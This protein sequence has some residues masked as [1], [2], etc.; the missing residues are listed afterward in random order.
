MS[1]KHYSFGIIDYFRCLES[2]TPSSMNI[3]EEC[4]CVCV[5]DVN[6][7]FKVEYKAEHSTVVCSL[8]VEQLGAL[9]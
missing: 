4:V 3:P 7:P 2:F 8:Q 9:H 6:A 5:C 1:E